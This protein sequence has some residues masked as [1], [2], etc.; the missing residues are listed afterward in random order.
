MS[1]Y[2]ESLVEREKIL[3]FH[4]FSSFFRPMI[5]RIVLKRRIFQRM[6]HHKTLETIR[7]TPSINSISMQ[8]K[9]MTRSTANISTDDSPVKSPRSIDRSFISSFFYFADF[10]DSSI[11]ARGYVQHGIYQNVKFLWK[12]RIC[13]FCFSSNF[14]FSTS[15]MVK[16]RRSNVINV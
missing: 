5:N 3:F 13:W 10:S 8:K 15:N 16:K 14:S 7:R 6:I 9:R 4:C 11:K 1:I 12:N 2:L